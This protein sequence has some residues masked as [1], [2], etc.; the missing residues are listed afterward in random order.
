MK[1]ISTKLKFLLAGFTILLSC[2]TEENIKPNLGII[3]ILDSNEQKGI[4]SA[5]AS[6]RLITDAIK[7]E[8]VHQVPI[9]QGGE[10][11]EMP[12]PLVT[13]SNGN[14]FYLEA[15]I[16]TTFTSVLPSEASEYFAGSF[17]FADLSAFWKIPD[18]DPN[19]I[20]LGTGPAKGDFFIEKSGE[21]IWRG[22]ITGIRL[23][24]G[25]D[26][27]PLFQWK[28]KIQA[29]GM[30]EYRG[31]KLSATETTEPSPFPAMVYYWSGVI[32]P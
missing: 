2:T 9:P 14:R 24:V 16:M 3:E 5:S 8:A 19:L 28:G 21:L 31:L 18:S 30:G 22:T 27:Q 29:E 25:T 20:M 10:M 4:S 6:D 17:L 26:E 7:F 11:P 13:P 1:K 23:N 32:A 15:S 12:P